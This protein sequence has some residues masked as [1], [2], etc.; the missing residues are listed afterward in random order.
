MWLAMRMGEVIELMIMAGFAL[1]VV[2]YM[3]TAQVKTV[4]GFAGVEKYKELATKK[5]L[6]T[7]TWNMLK[8]LPIIFIAWIFISIAWAVITF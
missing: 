7:N 2:G 3:L 6:F 8:M 4:L 1:A 5:L